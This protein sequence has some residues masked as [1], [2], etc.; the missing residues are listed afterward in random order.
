[1]AWA[2]KADQKG[3]YGSHAYADGERKWTATR[4]DLVFASNSVLRALAEVYASDDA[5]E[6]FVQD[7]A[8]AWTKVM[9]ADLF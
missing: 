8:K 6:K 4:S 9:K 1:M 2:P 3:V 5:N 7:F